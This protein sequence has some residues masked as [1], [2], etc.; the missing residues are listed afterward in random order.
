M[1]WYDRMILL[2]LALWIGGGIF[3]MVGFYGLQKSRLKFNIIRPIDF[4]MT[5]NNSGKP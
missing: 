1:V 2:G 4:P 3:I 5:Q